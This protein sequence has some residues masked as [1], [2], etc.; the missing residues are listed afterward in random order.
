ML[1][2][3]EGV[4][5]ALNAGGVRYLIVG[6]VAVVLYGHLRTTVDLDLVL[7][8]DDANVRKALRVFEGLGYIPRAPVP[9]A[10]FADEKKRSRWIEEKNMLVF[11]LYR[12]DE[13]AFEVDLFVREPF[14]FETVW[15]RRTVVQLEGVEAPVVSLQDLRRLKERAGRPQ[16]MA[17]LEALRLL[18]GGD[19]GSV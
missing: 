16:D 12:P 17:D 7:D 18:D 5:A 11:S 8:L 19:R 2:T 14:D 1:G 13:T 4:C 6:G 3:I 9:L 15:Q 10:D